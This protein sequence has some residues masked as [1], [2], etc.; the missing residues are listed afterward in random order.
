MFQQKSEIKAPLSLV[1]RSVRL[2]VRGNREE[3]DV[4]KEALALG[5]VVVTVG[6][7]KGAEWIGGGRKEP[8]DVRVI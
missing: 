4:R 6:A 2:R 8:S 7:G 1:G 5:I 3:G